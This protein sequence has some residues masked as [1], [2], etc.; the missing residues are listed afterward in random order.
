MKHRGKVFELAVRD[1][2]LSITKIAEKLTAAGLSTSQRHIYNLFENHDLPLDYFIHGGVILNHDFAPDIPELKKY[3]LAF[4]H[5][6]KKS[7]D[8]G[9]FKE[10]FYNQLEETNTW[11]AKYNTLLESKVEEYMLEIRAAR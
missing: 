5:Y 8:S 9:E 4:P 6:N 3:L 2:D 10:K 1:S 7:K 11:M